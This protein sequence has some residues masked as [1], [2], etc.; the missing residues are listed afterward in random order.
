MS[1]LKYEWDENKN[2]KNIENHHISFELAVKVFSDPYRMDLYD[3]EHS[4]INPYG[5]WEDRYNTIGY[6]GDLLF[7]VYTVRAEHHD[8]IIR[9]ISA[10]PA[11][12]IEIED[13]I[14]NRGMI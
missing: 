8:E 11:V 10:R 12:G 3:E 4:G 13:Y 2:K 7:V 5:E 6:I 1:R 14:R 9:I